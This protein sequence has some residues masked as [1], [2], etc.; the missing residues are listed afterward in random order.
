VAA[1]SEGSFVVTGG[2]EPQRLVGLFVGE[3]YFEA[4]AAAPLIGRTFNAQEYL[5]NQG[6]VVVI[7][8]GLWMR[9]FGGDPKVVNS[10][11][12]LSVVPHVIVGVMPKDSTWP[13]DAEIFRPNGFGGTPPAWAMRRDNHIFQAVA[14]LHTGVSIQQA[15]VRLTAMAARIAREAT[16]RQGTSWKLHSLRDWIVG[17]I[18]RQTLFVSVALRENARSPFATLSARAGGVSPASF[19]RRATCSLSPAPLRESQS[20][21]PA[22]KP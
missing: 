15:Q 1:H 9:R 3:G 20:V 22:S 10:T 17:P 7:A 6:N 16:H 8:Y 11:I 13:A 19:S 12:E 14:R 2:E 21:M 5:P 18:I 4:M